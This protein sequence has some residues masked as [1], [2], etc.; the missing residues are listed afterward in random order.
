MLEYTLG[1]ATAMAEPV[2]GESQ[3]LIVYIVARGE[4]DAPADELGY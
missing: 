1:R 4:S 2:D 3:G